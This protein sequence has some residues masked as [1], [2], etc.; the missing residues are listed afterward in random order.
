MNLRAAA[1][2]VLLLPGFCGRTYAQDLQGVTV[3]TAK[4][5][6]SLVPLAVVHIPLVPVYGTNTA[7]WPLI[8][9]DHEDEPSTYTVTDTTT[10]KRLKIERIEHPVSPISHN[11]DRTVVYLIIRN[12]FSAGDKVSVEIASGAKTASDISVENATKMSFALNPQAAPSEKLTNNQKRDVGQ[13]GIKLDLPELTPGWT[14]ARTYF[15]TDNL[16]STDEKDTKSKVDAKVGVERSLISG[17]YLPAHIEGET[18]GDQVAA[19]FSALVGAGIKTILPWSFTK[20]AIYNCAFQAP[21]SPTFSLDLQYERRVNQDTQSRGKFPNRNGMRIH[22]QNS[23]SPVRLLPGVIGRDTAWL[24]LN[25]QA[26]YLPLEEDKSHKSTPRLEG[27][28]DVSFVL[29]LSKLSSIPGLSYLVGADAA[30]KRIRLKYSA[31]ADEATGF[32][33]SH[34]FTAGIELAK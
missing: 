15:T 10:K 27:A 21:I 17:W 24:E 7:A 26:W 18:Q 11:P 22:E 28:G 23:W 9:R 13:F 20:P 31:G 29:S 4:Q 2:S 12:D 5:F 14:G 30:H 8:L 25:G 3:F 33:H 1:L 6:P 16:I 32:K 19:N 34:Q